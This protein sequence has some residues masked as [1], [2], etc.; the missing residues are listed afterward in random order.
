ML[1][2]AT[3]RQLRAVLQSS[4]ALGLA[5][6]AGRLAEAGCRR[7]R[8]LRTPP[9]RVIGGGDQN[10]VGDHPARQITQLTRS[11]MAQRAQRRGQFVGALTIVADQLE[12]RYGLT[13]FHPDIEA[14]K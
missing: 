13:L 1:C 5:S 7:Q 8:S 6:Q 14:L 12:T 10:V 4:A 9:S 2:R 3:N 11:L